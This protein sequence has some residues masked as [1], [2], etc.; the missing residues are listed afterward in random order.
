MEK[1]KRIIIIALII[2]FALPTF[3]GEKEDLALQIYIS[4]RNF[5]ETIQE[6]QLLK[7]QIEVDEKRLRELI[8]G[9]KPELERKTMKSEDK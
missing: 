6:L 9:K 5:R 3:A 4:K 7:K 8:E 2:G 1:I